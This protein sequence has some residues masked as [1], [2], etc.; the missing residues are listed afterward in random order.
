MA[1]EII[2]GDM[3]VAEVLGRVPG[4]L[5]IFE[6]H[7]VNPR[8]ACGPNIH[9]LGL[10]ETPARCGLEELEQMIADLNAAVAAEL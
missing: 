8:T 1:E 7:G 3:T 4:C 9:I 10:D 5:R 2:T 6:E